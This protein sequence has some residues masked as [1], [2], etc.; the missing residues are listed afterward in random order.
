MKMFFAR[1]WRDLTQGRNLPHWAAVSCALVFLAGRY[2]GLF[3]E[4]LLTKVTLI[5]LT[6]IL[7]GNIRQSWLLEEIKPRIVGNPIG[8]YPNWDT[9]A[10]RKSLKSAKKSIT[11]FQSWFPDATTI[12]DRIKARAGKI[13]PNRQLEVEIFLL[14]PTNS[15]PVGAQRVRELNARPGELREVNESDIEAFKT[16]H[17][18]KF[19]GCIED[20]VGRLQNC[21][22]V[23]LRILAYSHLPNLKLYSVDDHDFFFSWLPISEP[24][25]SNI[26]L[27]IEA[28]SGNSDVETVVEKLREHQEHL[29]GTARQVWP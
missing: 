4:V 17:R 19:D 15:I 9:K 23:E 29:R 2:L 28:D 11:L 26:C 25:T 7:L 16:K 20:F 14:D 6:V 8:V 18:E 12:G 3:P 10:V 22:A 21:P 5:V 24:S 1:M 27:H 13:P